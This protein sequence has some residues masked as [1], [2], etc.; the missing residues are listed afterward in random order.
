MTEIINLKML[1]E[2][3]QDLLL[4]YAATPERDLTSARRTQ[5]KFMAELDRVYDDQSS[6]QSVT[7]RGVILGWL[8]KWIASRD[9]ISLFMGRRVAIYL[10]FAMVVIGVFLSGGVGITAYAAGSSLPG[11]T[12]YPL[13]TTTESVRAR[14][15][16][17]STA[18]AYLYLDFAGQRL[19]EME[20]LIDA[21]RFAD[22]DDGA[23]ELERDLEGILRVIETIP[24]QQ[25]GKAAAL[26][27]ET[28]AALQSYS[29]TLHQMLQEIPEEEQSGVLRA[30][31]LAESAAA[32]LETATGD[33]DDDDDDGLTGGRGGEGEC[34][35]H[36]PGSR[37][38]DG[39]D[40]LPGDV[41][42]EAT[43]TPTSPAAPSTREDNNNNSG[44][45]QDGGSGDNDDDG[46]DDNGDDDGDDDDD[47][48]EGDD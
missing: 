39:C 16:A 37:D 30:T 7:H 8:D 13:K 23:H 29:D 19:D 14:W 43:Q 5:A 32:M 22:L 20:T 47:D 26:R 3:M 38:D 46:N 4:T 6:S 12:L 40:G 21:G 27:G 48:D 17:D 1:D 28:V 25:P 31:H 24:Q 44:N 35:A 2:N 34:L 36:S 33:Q 45:N 11:D 10:L 41:G 9:G 42:E 15:T 18:R